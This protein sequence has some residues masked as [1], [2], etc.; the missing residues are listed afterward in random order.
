MDE[1]LT[2]LLPKRDGEVGQVG[3]FGNIP[4]LLRQKER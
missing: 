2:V 3:G 1:L 4:M